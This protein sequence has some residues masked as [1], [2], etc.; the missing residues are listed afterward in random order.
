[1]IVSGNGS[2]SSFVV[3][4]TT[5]MMVDSNHTEKMLQTYSLKRL[6]SLDKVYYP[7]K[8]AL[9]VGKHECYDFQKEEYI[10]G[11]GMPGGDKSTGGAS[12]GYGGGPYSS[13]LADR[14]NYRL[15][16]TL[17]NW[18]KFGETT[19]ATSDNEWYLNMFNPLCDLCFQTTVIVDE[20]GRRYNVHTRNAGYVLCYEDSSHTKLITGVYEN[21]IPGHESDTNI[22]SIINQYSSYWNI[23][24]NKTSTAPDA[25]TLVYTGTAKYSGGS[26]TYYLKVYVYCQD[27]SVTPTDYPNKFEYN[28]K[29]SYCG[30]GGYWSFG[31]TAYSPYATKTI[32][33]PD[34]K[35]YTTLN[36]TLEEFTLSSKNDIPGY[37]GGTLLFSGNNLDSHFNADEKKFFF[38]G[39]KGIGSSGTWQS[40]SETYNYRIKAYKFNSEHFKKLRTNVYAFE[41]TKIAPVNNFLQRNSS[42]SVQKQKH[43]IIG[44][45]FLKL[46]G[47]ASQYNKGDNPPDKQYWNMTESNNLDVPDVLSTMHYVTTDEPDSYVI[48]K[49]VGSIEYGDEGYGLTFGRTNTF[50]YW[51]VNLPYLITTGHPLYFHSNLTEITNLG[52]CMSAVTGIWPQDN[53]EFPNLTA[54][55][56]TW[57]NC[58]NFK[59]LAFYKVKK[60]V[61]LPDSWIG[62]ESCNLGWSGF[63]GCEALTGI[64]NSWQGLNNLTGAAYMFYNGKSIKSLP[65][66]WEGLDSLI[67]SYNM[68]ENCTNI[69]TINSWQ[70]L[71]SLQVA[72]NMFANCTKLTTIPSDWSPLKAIVDLHSCFAGCSQLTTIPN[73]DNISPTLDNVSG[74]FAGCYHLVTLPNSW[75]GLSS[76]RYAGQMFS[77]CSDLTT[78]PTDISELDS[79]QMCDLQEMFNGCTKLKTDITPICQYINNGGAGGI[80]RAK[81]MFRGC[82]SVPNYDTLTATYGYLF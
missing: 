37:Y 36:D 57:E 23:V 75:K 76:V 69:Q 63:Y 20:Y 28:D 15:Y 42:V 44:P 79:N 50:D 43:Q 5:G 60:L 34:N 4:L 81:G 61:S 46:T 65:N 13:W 77:N 26:P 1:M 18:Y 41:D 8:D 6:Y 80:A 14:Q 17:P 40:E 66:T 16:Y 3:P 47:Y 22:R 32:I 10:G 78:I 31:F 2:T 74:M 70:G 52:T 64:P 19:S 58:T 82:T 9:V 33:N 38:I 24:L 53:S 73:W 72:G 51:R 54:I 68:F 11:K 45:F 21:N 12:N 56:G 39:F 29:L 27:S 35:S 7:G 25:R 55:K 71:S 59:Q 62:L 48:T 67:Y 49:P 30:G